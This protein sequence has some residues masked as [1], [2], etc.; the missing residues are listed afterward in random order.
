MAAITSIVGEAARV[1]SINDGKWFRITLKRSLIGIDWRTRRCAEALKLRRVGQTVY[2]KVDPC[3]LGNI[4]K[5]KEL[6]AIAIKKGLPP[7][8]A[9]GRFPSGYAVIG[10][11]LNK[12]FI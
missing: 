4:F 9:P 1:A 5:L 12:S 10:N 11:M 2:K 6:V 3:I 8:N 7:K